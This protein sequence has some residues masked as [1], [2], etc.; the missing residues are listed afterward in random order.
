MVDS[1]SNFDL[2]KVCDAVPNFKFNLCFHMNSVRIR[3]IAL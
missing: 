2:L 1:Y 3:F